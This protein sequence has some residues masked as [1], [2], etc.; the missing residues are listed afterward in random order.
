MFE[1]ITY[2][3]VTFYL[4]HQHSFEN[5]KNLLKCLSRSF[6]VGDHQ[7]CDYKH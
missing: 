1:E 4:H 5:S 3:F 7:G 6:I 2:F